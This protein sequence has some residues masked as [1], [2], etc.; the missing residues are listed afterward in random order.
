MNKILS[1][2]ASLK[3]PLTNAQLEILGLFSENLSEQD[4]KDLHQWLLEFRYRRLQNTLNQ[5]ADEKGW[6]EKTFEE[7][8]KAHLRQ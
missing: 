5:V 6:T 7:W 1:M 8:G 2:T 3:Q 4:M